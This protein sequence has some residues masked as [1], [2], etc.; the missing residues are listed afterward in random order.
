MPLIRRSVALVTVLAV[1]LS[2]LAPV[3]LAANGPAHLGFD[4]NQ[5]PGD[6]NL[7]KLHKTFAFT[8][9]WLNNPP[10]EK[11]NTW[12]GKRRQIE[13]AGLGFAVL[14]NGRLYLELK[15]NAAARG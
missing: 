13:A 3:A 2:L 4:R 7:E 14:F 9:Y 6:A 1:S 15:I 8:G 5:Y 11:T 10:G 12:T